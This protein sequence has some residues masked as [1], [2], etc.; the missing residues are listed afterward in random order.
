M[1]DYDPITTIESKFHISLKRKSGDEYVGPCPLT[2]G[3]QGDDRFHVWSERGNY[4]CRQCDSNGFVDEFLDKPIEPIDIAKIAA[5][6]AKRERELLDLAIERAQKVSQELQKTEKWMEYYEQAGN[7]GRKL[8]ELRGIPEEWQGFWQLGYCASSPWNSPTLSIPIRGDHD[9]TVTNIKHRLLL[10]DDVKGKYRYEKT[11]IPASSFICL[12]NLNTGP[13][14]IAE[15]EIKALVTC[16]TIDDQN[17][18]V[19]GLPSVSPNEQTMSIFE[20]HEPIYVCL[21]PDAYEKKN[22]K[23]PPAIGK[24]ISLLGNE[25]VR[26]IELPD[27]IDDLIVAGVLT[28]GRLQ[29]IIKRARKP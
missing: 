24:V 1:I 22:P 3:G 10:N 14:F 12:P 6:R 5:E 9:W 8:W 13:L 28:R 11:G 18:Q 19:A 16:L 2:C 7:R 4:W 20:N 29:N 21:D 23:Q 27:K 26:V 15:G 25:R 17:L